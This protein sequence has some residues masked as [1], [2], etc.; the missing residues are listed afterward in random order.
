MLKP[1]SFKPPS[2]IWVI[3][4]V[5]IIAGY[6]P[7]NL[8]ASEHDAKI[9]GDQT[10][11]GCHDDIGGSFNNTVHF[12]ANAEGQDVAVTCESCHGGG[13]MH[14][15][16]GNTEYIINPANGEGPE[17]AQLCVVCH[18]N[19]DDDFGF[20]HVEETG[21]C[22]S[23][24]SIHSTNKGLLKFQG[25]DLCLS[26]HV[27]QRASFALPSHHPVFE[28]KMECVDC[29]QVHGGGNDFVV[30]NDERDLCLSCHATK[31]GPFIFE[32]DPVNENCSICH[33][34]HGTVAD[35]LLIQ[36]EPMLCLSCH[37]MHFHTSLAGYDGEFT[38]PLHPER[39]GVSTL[40][41]FKQS[42]LT[43]CSQCHTEIH[44]SDLPAQS[45][46]GPGALTR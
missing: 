15:E 34:P 18:G 33:D 31:Q 13:S 3:V 14:A 23:C 27:D 35:N 29:H 28:G 8:L 12:L 19:V 17:S 22:M 7:A 32:H 37:P 9:I 45:I 42:M 2:V 4:A 46:T 6:C 11:L 26:C 38:A 10:C 30:V 20:S 43:K 41:G 16:E 21:N 36:S 5:A 25:T 39:G 44:G 1:I 24:H 40:D